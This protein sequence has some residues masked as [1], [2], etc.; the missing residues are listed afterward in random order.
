MALAR[1]SGRI[2]KVLAC[3]PKLRSLLLCVIAASPPAIAAAA[4]AAAATAT[5][6]AAAAATAAAKDHFP[7]ESIYPRRKRETTRSRVYTAE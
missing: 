1:P 5:A 2:A 4:T 3:N 7:L 6:A